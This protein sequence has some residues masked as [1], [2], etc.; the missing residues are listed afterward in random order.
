MNG[1]E[2]ATDISKAIEE[3]RSAIV[4]S[5]CQGSTQNCILIKNIL[6]KNLS[7]INI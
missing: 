4:P 2:L 3:A 7:I 1:V 6:F 5:L